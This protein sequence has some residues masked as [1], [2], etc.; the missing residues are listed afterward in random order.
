MRGLHYIPKS[1]GK[2]ICKQQGAL[3]LSI[4]IKNAQHRSS[5]HGAAETN[6]TRNHEVAGTIPGPAQ[7]VKDSALQ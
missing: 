4:I 6:P 2:Q 5:C 3:G 1:L 7:W